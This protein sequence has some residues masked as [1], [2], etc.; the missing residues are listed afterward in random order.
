MYILHPN[1]D[2]KRAV[3]YISLGFR[4]QSKLGIKCMSH[5]HRAKGWGE[6]TRREIVGRESRANVGAERSRRGAQ[7][8]PTRGPGS[9]RKRVWHCH[10]QGSTLAE[11]KGAAREVRGED[12][13]VTLNLP[14]CR[15][16]GT[17]AQLQ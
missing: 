9:R 2:G 3:G 6:T 17:D 4:E 15:P 5:W 13:E 14:T 7:S 12:R 10:G 8:G 1:R 16:L 11:T